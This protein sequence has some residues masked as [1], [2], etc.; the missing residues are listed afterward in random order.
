MKT[1]IT[2]ITTLMLMPSAGA[3]TLTYGKCDS[4]ACVERFKEIKKHARNHVSANTL[5]GDMYLN[6]YGTDVNKDEALEA[7]EKASRWGSI[8][9][10]YKAGLM[11]VTRDDAESK[12]EGMRYLRDAAKKGHRNAAYFMGEVLSNPKYGVQNVAEADQWLAVL[13]EAKHEIVPQTLAR[14]DREGRLNE[15]TFPATLKA[16]ST[17]D[18]AVPETDKQV[19]V[20]AGR[21]APEDDKY[22]VIEVN[23]PQL[24]ELID[25]GIE[26]YEEAPSDL[27]KVTT[28]TRI[29]GRS[30][31]DRMNGCGG[32][33]VDQ[34]IRYYRNFIL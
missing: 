6:G 16:M 13:V 20:K 21:A 29:R 8:Y 2:L 28:G 5:L 22:E 3:L 33:P 9:G 24:A 4:D 17:Y 23:G 26:F 10:K 1:L 15:E 11:L 34:F 18:M 31:S 19:E 12:E 27:N 32:A 30:C 7:F 14:L 25:V